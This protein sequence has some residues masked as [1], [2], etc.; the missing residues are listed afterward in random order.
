MRT[1]THFL[2]LRG[3]PIYLISD[4]HSNLPAL[5]AVLKNIPAEATIVCAGDMLGYYLN[6]N[7]VCELL[8]TRSVLCIQGNHD[9]YV[10]G[11]L[12][13]PANR[14]KKYRIIK[15]RQLLT[16][17]NRQ[18]LTTLPDILILKYIPPYAEKIITNNSSIRIAHG[19]PRSV[20]EYIYPDTSI[21][22]LAA[23]SPGFLI[24]GHTHHP[25][26][27]QAGEVTVI[28]PGSVGQARDRI[29]GA[30]YASLDS[31]SGEINFYRV[32]YSIKLYQKLLEDADVQ[33]SMIEMLSRTHK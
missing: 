14:E 25:M 1:L 4:I 24:L 12:E 23:D 13:Y 2:D 17:E 7:E 32:N 20:N 5:E 21:D 28:N 27:R 31:F 29:P 19:S 16:D 3:K 30:C 15:T 33:F 22:F 9:K 6:P 11:E 26:K 18:W 8:R 10:L